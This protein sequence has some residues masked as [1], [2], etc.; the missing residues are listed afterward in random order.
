MIK[1]FLFLYFTLKAEIKIL[2]ILK[3]YHTDSIPYVFNAEQQLSIR[4]IRMGQ[5]TSGGCRWYSQR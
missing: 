2:F 1:R 5:F 3:A 4:R